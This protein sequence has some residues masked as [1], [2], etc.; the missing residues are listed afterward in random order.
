[1]TKKLNKG[2][3]SLSAADTAIL[4]SQKRGSSP[5]LTLLVNLLIEHAE[6]D[7]Q[8]ENTLKRSG[9]RTFPNSVKVDGEP[10][11]PALAPL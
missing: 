6:S 2:E 3:D 7:L 9:L 10:L 4:L 8:H 5:K 1:M 11:S